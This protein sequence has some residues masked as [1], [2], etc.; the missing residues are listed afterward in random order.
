MSRRK[1]CSTCLMFIP[2]RGVSPEIFEMMSLMY[3]GWCAEY[4]EERDYDEE[5]CECYKAQINRV[6]ESIGKKIK[7]R[8]ES[9]K[10]TRETLAMLTGVSN[11]SIS[12]YENH[13]RMP[14]QEN[15]RKLAHA[16]RVS[17]EWLEK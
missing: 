4:H 1:Q 7:A 2:Q 10:M 11:S 13:Q 16:L 14:S 15:I 6:K 17:R 3:D 9:L 12:A 5:V 8:R